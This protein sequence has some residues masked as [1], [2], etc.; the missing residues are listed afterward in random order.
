VLQ[1]FDPVPALKRQLADKVLELLDGWLNTWGAW[2][3]RLP[4]SRISAMRGG[5]LENVS[6]ERLIRCLAQL[7]HSVTLTVLQQSRSTWVG[8]PLG[9]PPNPAAARGG[10]AGW[11][12]RKAAIPELDGQ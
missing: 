3:A 2:H 6:L 8:E 11:W 12:L 1:A 7:D 5:N 10:E 9:E 4:R